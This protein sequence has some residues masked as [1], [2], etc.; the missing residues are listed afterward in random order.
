MDGRVRLLAK[1]T[2]SRVA[3]LKMA[4]RGYHGCLRLSI[5]LAPELAWTACES[6]PDALRVA[7]RDFSANDCR[8]CRLRSPTIRSRSTVLDDVLDE[9]DEPAVAASSAGG[10]S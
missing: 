6:I 4:P 2:Y 5:C 8:S 3:K 10:C 1:R 7:A 9:G